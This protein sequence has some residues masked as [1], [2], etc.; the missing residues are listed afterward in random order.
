MTILLAKDLRLSL[1][2][3]RPW[4]LIVLG[5][6]LIAGLA[7]LLPRS[8]VPFN[9]G[10]STASELVATIGGL[11]GITCIA[12]AAWIAASVAHGEERHGA[13]SLHSALPVGRGGRGLSKAAAILAGTLA[14]AFV[15][16]LLQQSAGMGVLVHR[17][18]PGLPASWVLVGALAGAGFGMG[19][20]SATR[21]VFPTVMIALL[22]AVGAA[23]AGG[24]GAAVVFPVAAA[25][26]LAVADAVGQFVEVGDARART[27]LAG[28]A[29]GLGV[30]SLLSACIG[31]RAFMRPLPVVR[32]AI[33]LAMTLLLASV[34]GA[35]AVPLAL[36]GDSINEWQH[37]RDRDVVLASDSEVIQAIGRVGQQLRN[38]PGSFV[39]EVGD[40][41]FIDIAHRRLARVPEQERAGHLLAIA[42][43][44]AAYYDEVRAAIWSLRL[45]PRNP[46]DR[47]DHRYLEA[48][49]SVVLRYREAPQ[50]QRLLD[51]PVA[52]AGGWTTQ[53]G[54]MPEMNAVDSGYD[55]DF[56]RKL[57][58]RLRTLRDM[59]EYAT[60]RD[61]MDAV[62]A[63]LERQ[64]PAPL[65]PEPE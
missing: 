61:Q 21:G 12:A 15:S 31:I 17:F 63:N 28:A 36:A 20:A 47:D 25:K 9:S 5:F 46:L 2:A 49:L 4:A 65:T 24:G 3:L 54:A 44:E 64:Q 43:N 18:V 57:I 53:P 29:L 22:L 60:L 37:Y 26:Y 41:R 50:I 10:I 32:A 11:A 27:I 19:I 39:A 23:L 58:G 51:L 1:D 55:R 7:S 40:A 13:A 35:F 52:A 56:D 34:A 8:L 16:I 14:V 6:G 33:A 48:A 30:A 59:P 42:L 38:D 45:I 62:L